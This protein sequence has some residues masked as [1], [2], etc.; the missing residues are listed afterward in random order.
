M[1]I[2]IF[3]F[4]AALLLGSFLNVVIYRIPR[5]ESVLWPGSHCP[6]CNHNLKALDLIPVLSYVGLGGR[7]RY[8][9]KSISLRYPLVE[10]ITAAS[11]LMMYNRWGLTVL[12]LSGFIFTAILIITAFTD[13][14]EGIIP[15]RITYPGM[16]IGLVLSFFTIGIQPALIGMLTFAGFLLGAALLSRGG[17]GGGDIKLA[18]LIGSFLGLSG[19]M[20]TLVLASVLGSIWA[21]YLLVLKKADRKTAIKFGP[22][23]SIS[24]WLV[25]M[26]G[27]AMIDLYLSLF[28]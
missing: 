15:D 8:C 1:Y 10:I 9:K 7:C 19:S 17:M 14:E 22:F 13:I 26:Y 21:V 20:L 5:R 16:A 27:P 12:T 18:G 2:S 11:G 25:L 28:I 4:I 3:V 24:A 23:L 6:G